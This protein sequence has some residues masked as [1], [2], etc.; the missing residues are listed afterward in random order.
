MDK[1]LGGRKRRPLE[2]FSAFGEEE[3]AWEAEAA[4]MALWCGMGFEILGIWVVVEMEIEVE[5]GEE[6]GGRGGVGGGQR[7]DHGEGSVVEEG[8]RYE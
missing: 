1:V 4:G 3:C 5:W 7:V 8:L 2:A 6:C